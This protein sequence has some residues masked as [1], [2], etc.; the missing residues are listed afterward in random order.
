MAN[1]W[2][3]TVPL[4]DFAFACGG[5]GEVLGGVTMPNEECHKQ[6]ESD[7]H[8]SH[9]SYTKRCCW[10]SFFQDSLI[11]DGSIRPVLGH[12]MFVTNLIENDV[13]CV[14]YID[15]CSS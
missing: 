9:S 2:I 14:Y 3:G 4:F 10:D 7:S 12:K 5:G 1:D 11:R 15:Y 8:K 6:V 13:I